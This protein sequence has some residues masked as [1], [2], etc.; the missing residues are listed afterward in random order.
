MLSLDEAGTTATLV[1][2]KAR[3]DELAA[4]LAVMEP[5]NMH[6]VP[7]AEM[8]ELDLN[9]F[10]VARLDGAIIGAA[11]Y[12]ILSATEGKTTLLGVLPEHSR[13]RVGAMLQEARLRAMLDAGVK[14]VTTNADR[15]SVIRW[16]KM[17]FGYSEVGT[18]QKLHSFGH[19]DIDHWTT[20]E[21]D[22]T[23]WGLS[24]QR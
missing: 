16:Y 10:F 21:L 2:E 1:I 17:S 12:R 13:L 8:G 5:W 14:T 19:P 23:A 9:C 18:L 4:V 20:L 24:R 22:L 3:P 7:S 15:P 6:H 11:G